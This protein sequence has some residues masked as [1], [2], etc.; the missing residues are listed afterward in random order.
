MKI[1][2]N[3]LGVG[4]GFLSQFAADCASFTEFLFFYSKKKFVGSF[5]AFE[6]EKNVLV[7]FFMMKRGRYNRTFLHF[8]TIGLLGLGVIIAPILADTF[9]IFS[10]QTQVAR[11]PSPD[12][13]NQSITVDENVFQTHTSDNHRD[14]DITYTVQRGDT[15]STIAQK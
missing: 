8:A 11:L 2:R 7:H 13:A 3:I 9:P 14:K 4:I 6:K 15:L 5:S 12:S 1:V 10:T